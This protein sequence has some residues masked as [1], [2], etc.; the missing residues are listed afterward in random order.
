[1]TAEKW[2]PLRRENVRVS[3]TQK[4]IADRLFEKREKDDDQTDKKGEKN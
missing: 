4:A 3:E 1:M 2:N